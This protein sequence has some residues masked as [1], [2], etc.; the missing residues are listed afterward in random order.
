MLDLIARNHT[1]V[2]MFHSSSIESLQQQ[3][4]T[5]IK[6]KDVIDIKYNVLQDINDYNCFNYSVLIHYIQ[7]EIEVKQTHKKTYEKADDKWDK[8]YNTIEPN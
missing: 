3:V 6:S 5:F 4:N 7:Y 1:Q 8:D 2:K